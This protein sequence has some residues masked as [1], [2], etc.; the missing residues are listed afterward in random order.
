[1]DVTDMSGMLSINPSVLSINPS[2]GT[3]AQIRNTGCGR[4]DRRT[5][6]DHDARSKTVKRRGKFIRAFVDVTDPNKTD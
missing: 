1:M 5:V 4:F 2:V 6:S 3:C